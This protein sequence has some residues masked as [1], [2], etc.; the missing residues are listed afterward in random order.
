MPLPSSRRR[1]APGEFSFF[2]RTLAL[3][4][5]ATLLPGPLPVALAV[6]ILRHGV[7]GAA[8]TAQSQMGSGVGAGSGADNT[9][10]ARQNATDALARTTAA[11]D[12]VQQM[13]AAAHAL[14][15]TAPTTNLGPNP[16]AAG[17][18]PNVQDGLAPGGL[19]I[20][21]TPTG[22][23]APAQT[24][25]TNGATTVN[26]VQNQ[27]QAFINW[28]SF[29]IGKNTTLNFDQSAGGAS[30]GQWIAF[31]NVTD[32]TGNPAQILGSIHAQ[33]QV[34][35]MDQNGIIFGGSSQVNVNTLVAS[36]LPIN[37]NLVNN[38]LLNQVDVQYLFSALPQA[39]GANGTPAV[40][41]DAPLTPS[42]NN[43]DVT[44]QA[45]AQLVS[46]SV[47]G[48]GGRIA[49]IGP[50]VTNNGSISTP[51]GQTIIAGGLQVGFAAHNSSD[52]S[53]RGLD[54]YVGSVGSYGGSTTNTG[55]IDAPRGNVTMT[56][57]EVNQD[58]VITST[59]SVALNGRIDLNASYN[60][61]SNVGYNTTLYP[62]SPPYLYTSS[63]TVNVGAGAVTQILPEWA[64]T[65][66][67]VGTQLALVSQ[68][69]VT[70]QAIY[71][72]V[73]STMLAPN[74]QVTISAGIWDYV[75]T[76]MPPVS[77][78]IQTG[79]QIY[80]DSGAM[81]NVAGSTDV[82]ASVNEY[83]LTVQLRSN[84]L[85]DSP[86]QRTGVLDNQTVTVDLR[87]TGT[88]NGRVW[89]GT[90]LADLAGY[91]GVIQRTVGELTT[92]GGTISLKAGDSVVLQP[93]ANLNVSG[94]WIN[95]QGAQV[96]TTQLI[97][98][99]QIINIATATPNLVYSGIYTGQ[100]TTTQAA[101]GATSTTTSLFGQ[102][103]FLS[104]SYT[105][106]GN[107]GDLN[108]AAPAMALDGSMYGL[109][110]M[111]IE[112]R[113]TL[114]SI[115]TLSLSF[116]AQADNSSL[117]YPLT[118]PTQPT[119]YL[120]SG[121][122]QSVVAPFAVSAADVPLTTLS[123]AR[124]LEV[125]LSPT[126]V[127]TNGF[128]QLSISNVN[129]SIIVPAATSLITAPLGAVNF[130]AAIVDI[131]GSILSRGGSISLTAYD[132][133]PDQVLNLRNNPTQGLPAADLTRG[134][135][136]IGANAVLAT[137]GL[138]VDE[139]NAAGLAE[140]LVTQGGSIAITGMTVNL[141]AGGMLDVSGGARVS[142]AAQIS[143]GNGGAITINSGQDAELKGV[144][145]G[146]LT[147]DSIMRGFS[148]ATGGALNLLAPV[149]QV[150]GTTTDS[151][152]LL[153]DP[154]FF[155]QGGFNSFTLTGLGETTATTDVFNPAVVIAAGTVL[156]PVAQS[157]V[158]QL[159]SQTVTL[160]PQIL[161]E[162][163]RQAVKLDFEAPG[164]TDELLGL[165]VVRGE[166]MM[167]A[168]S[169]IQTDPLG[170]VKFNGGAV[171]LFG[172][173]TAPGGTITVTGAD[174]YPQVNTAAASA[175]ITVDLAPG[176]SL[177]TAGKTLLVPD[178]YGL[179]KG[180]VLPG[181]T[182]TVSGNIVAEAGALLNASGASGVLDLTPAEAGQIVHNTL[183]GGTANGIISVATRID[184]NGG[185]ISFKGSNMLFLDAT[186]NAQSGGPTAAG[187]SL[188]ISSGRFYDIGVSAKPDDLNILVTQ[189]TPSI[190]VPI[191]SAGDNAL[192]KTVNTAGG[193]IIAQQGYFHADTFENGGF[194][195]LTLSGNL[196][197]SGAVTL[198]AASSLT[199]ATGGVLTA[200]AAVNLNAPYVDLGMPFRA[201]LQS[202]QSENQP[203]LNQGQPYYVPPTYGPGTLSVSAASIDIGHLSLQST[204]LASFTALN[205][206][207]RGDGIL[208]VAGNITMTAGQVYTPTATSFTIAA[209]DYN[210]GAGP[211]SG[212]VTLVSSGL[213][214][215]PLSAGGTINVYAST[216]NQ[217]GTLVAPAG[218]INLGW[219][220]TGTSPQD[221]LSGAGI[222]SLSIP[223]TSNLNILAGSRTSVSE[224]DPISGLGVS[225]P[226][227]F[228]P[229]GTTW[230]DPTGKDI[231]GGGLPT[232]TVNTS[233]LNINV[234][235]GALID[236]RGG[237]DL[238]AFQ[239]V[240]GTGGTVDILASQGSFAV[241]PGYSSNYAPYA[242]FNSTSD[243]VNLAASQSGYTNSTLSVGDRV[244]LAGG[245]GLAAGV[246][247]LLP[248]RY[249]LLSGAFLVTPESGEPQGSSLQPDGA[250]LVSGYR[251]NALNTA[252]QAP[253]LYS[254]FEVAPTSVVNARA[255]YV[256]FN[257]S[258]FLQARAVALNLT[259][260][261]LPQDGG[262]LLLESV[263]G[264]TFN[265][266]IEGGGA[267]GGRGAAIDISS[268]ADILLASSGA[269]AAPGVLVLDAAQLSA[270]GAESLLI[271][272]QRTTT[273]AGTQVNVRTSNITVG[274]SAANSLSMPELI[275]VA[276]NSITVNPGASIVQTGTMV[277]AAANLLFGSSANPGSGNGA[278]L[279]VSSDVSAEML[280]S[281]VTSA[282]GPSLT[283][284][285]GANITGNSITLDSSNVLSLNTTTV[286]TG[287]A[288]N[289]DSGKISL[290]LNNP[291]T[292]QASPGLVIAG[293]VLQSIQQTHSLSLLSYSSI[294]IYGTGQVGSAQTTSL[295]LHAGEI[296]GFN[297][298]NPGSSTVTLTAQN[299]L[300]DNSAS[301]TVPGIVNSATGSLFLNAL[302]TLSIGANALNVDQFLG[303]NASAANGILLQGAGSLAV[304]GTF[305]AIAPV[306]TGA[307]FA[308][309]SIT[310]TGAM[311]LSASA[312]SG[313]LVVGGL[314]ASLSLTG[315]SLAT[316]T[317]I[318]LPSGQLSLNATSGD[319]TVTGTLNVGGT[320]Q[321]FFDQVKYT[322]AGSITLSSATGNVNLLAGSLV[323]IA[324]NAL[325]GNAGTL[326]VTTTAGTLNL[327]GTLSGA[328]PS[329][330]SGSFV[331]TAGTLPTLSALNSTLNNA[332]LDF[333]RSIRVLNGDVTVDGNTTSHIFNLSADQ[334]SITVTG[335][336]DASGAT[337][338]TIQLSAYG[339]IVLS[340]GLAKT[341]SLATANNLIS[342]SDTTGVAIGQAVSG[343]NIPAATYV[344]A[345][346]GTQITL[347]QAVTSTV[348]ASTSLNFGARLT[349]AAAN[350]DSA[351]KGGNISLMAGSERN[352][353][354]NTAAKLDLQTG[355]QIDL[356]VASNVASSTLN[357]LSNVAANVPTNVGG[358]D[359][360]TATQAGI[361]TLT[362]GDTLALAA[363]TPTSVVGAQ[364][365]TLSSNGTA[366]FA[367]STAWGDFTGTLQLRA[368]QNT[369]ATDLQMNP[370]NATITGASVITA[371]GY[372]IFTPTGGVLNAAYF[373]SNIKTNAT[374]FTSHTSAITSRLLANNGN[375]NSIFYLLPGAEI[376]NQ[377]GDLTLGTTSSKASVGDFDLSSA[378]YGP[379]LVP[380]VLTMRAEGNLVFY[381]SI[382]D[383]FTSSLYTAP[384]QA[385]NTNLPANLQSWSY[386]LAA[387]SDFTAVDFHQV[388][389]TTSPTLATGKGSLLL[390]RNDSAAISNNPGANA[391]TSATIGLPTSTSYK[392]QTIRTGTGSIDI[393]TARDVQFL[394]QFATIYTAGSQVADS[395][396]GGTFDVPQPSMQGTI[397]G[398]LGVNQENP[399]PAQYTMAGG[400]VNINA[401][402]NIIQLAQNSN[403]TISV[404]DSKRSMPTNWLYRRGAVDPLTGLFAPS[405]YSGGGTSDVA[406]TSW[407][408]DFNN[409]FEN[410][411]ALGG[412]NITLVAGHNVSNINADI[413]TNARMVGKDSLGNPIA[414]NGASL[415]ELGGGSLII[416]SGHNIDGGVYYVERGTG[417]LSAQ[418]AIVTN[419]TRSPS[420]GIITSLTT[421][422]VLDSSTWLPTTLF[423]GDSS[424]TVKAVGDIL[425][426]PVAN[427]FLM[428]QGYNNSY[429]YKTYFSTYNA[430]SAVNVSSLAGNVTLRQSITFA[431]SGSVNSQVPILQAWYQTQ[432]LLGSTQGGG[433]GQ[434]SSNYQPWL[435]LAEDSLQP[436]ATASTLMPGTLRVTAFTGSFDIVGNVNLSPS[437]TGTLEL[438]AAGAI[439]G[440]NTNGVTTFN[441]VS[442]N[443]WN[444]GTINL[445]DV[446]P[447]SLP[448]VT[449]PFAYQSILPSATSPLAQFTGQ[450]LLFT[451]LDTYFNETGS[452]TGS[453]AVLQ[454]KQALH[455]AG[456]LHAND[457]SPALIYA[458]TGSINGFTLFSA[459]ATQLISGLD[460]ADVSLY[461]QN[462][463]ASDLSIVASGRDIIP[464]DASTPLRILAQSNGNVLGQSQVPQAGDIQINGP[465]TLEVLS[466]RNIDLGVG[467]NNADGTG[468]GI[469]SIGNGRNPYLPFAGADII[470]AAGL[471]NAAVGISNSN[472]NFTSLISNFGTSS[473]GARYLGELEDALGIP[474]INLSDPSLSADQRDR[475]ALALFYLVLRDAGRDYNNPASPNYRSY[476]A[477]FQA[478]ADLF[479][480]AS[481]TGSI[482]TESRDIRTKSG[483]NISL[484]APG[485]GLTLSPTA[486]GTQ[487]APPGIITEAGGGINIFTNTSVSIGISRIFT[488]KGGDI[489]IWSSTGNI[490][491]GSSAKTV[492]SA[493]PTR[494]IIDP[495]S[496]SV[497]TD[498]AGLATGGGIGA[499]ATLSTI[500]NV[501]S[502]PSNIDLI[503]PVGAVDAGDAGIRATGNLNIAATIVLNSSNIQ[504]AGTTSGAPSAP[505]VAS[506]NIGGLSAANT[507]TAATNT[508]AM[509]QQ[510]QQQQQQTPVQDQ[511]SNFTVEVLGYGGGS[512]DTRQRNQ[513]GE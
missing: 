191:Y 460:I 24:V 371:E 468:A 418:G 101:F 240:S 368:P 150:G 465:G 243:S 214:N 348:P 308:S 347:S 498:L 162:G 332:G 211:Q 429:W 320:G 329:G 175:F 475:Y 154:A 294:D 17:T 356:S 282:S 65:A 140:P 341:T 250:S 257:A 18:L 37:D 323:N 497:N 260:P 73:G 23:T 247:T 377:T 480:N 389:A 218:V 376:I 467:S 146:G 263:V 405:Q 32:P 54:V 5:A 333:S 225:I 36:S 343:Q 169:L 496:G 388:L 75:D 83:I 199:L 434:T 213:R 203:L 88:Y 14:A 92:A 488:L 300:I 237:G 116:Q 324:A 232:K 35:V 417:A 256:G 378:R 61:I 132:I 390:G 448:S 133:A 147:L 317:D 312:A 435:K 423:V 221:P 117:S 292:L 80:V 302:N 40:T 49:L 216:I 241:L 102:G 222:T 369:A 436:F 145:G 422:T 327:G 394:N 82:S 179:R 245:S 424:F 462:N 277:S 482:N 48:S 511:E 58:G 122:V 301:G 67:V 53:L 228:S 319:T 68:I 254:S 28:S 127:N 342:L 138:I 77:T 398:N 285:A 357:L 209:Y 472:L 279:R 174:K 504:V 427:P 50:N 262:N 502:K 248:A 95:Y 176:S 383:G 276:N 100:T 409:F 339:S 318:E 382:S 110:V 195:S 74:A 473:T 107:G 128:G 173:V 108:I 273:T 202:Q 104:P 44:V 303:L 457:L 189:S 346:N 239:W 51:D 155:S 410:V 192:G 172:S 415:V 361:I 120:R 124:S 464:Y 359:T 170:S 400:N 200:N 287:Q 393:A 167:N 139:R 2:H 98:N 380:G 131:E 259:V 385:V 84:E 316:G 331:L 217:G 64:S 274:N 244:Y 43:G 297:N 513:P 426:G 151:R 63:G 185:T 193:S 402:G 509:G 86:L 334:G 305:S 125:D 443:V 362:N 30:V 466:G 201:P 103:S 321:T 76:S 363:N 224:I 456:L 184:S 425:L 3:V 454:T 503:A 93:T 354:I 188:S 474:S 280:R 499:L 431:N 165:L 70:G 322:D 130:S 469:T 401:Q 56:G 208:D 374:T 478:I 442:T 25:G 16:N 118:Y 296:R 27:Q 59:T 439:N 234:Q 492:Q 135:V 148:G 246:Y 477:G 286:L 289:I 284:G 158:A 157:W 106:G 298:S 29:N 275:L 364:S 163:V 489:V 182:I 330:Q 119:V 204:G 507:S 494:V 115:S 314:G 7:G 387:G 11:I 408:V 495:Q 196:Q 178:A 328:A 81:I 281:G 207:I 136:T 168:G 69:N 395:T 266:E 41:P 220:G 481:S 4:A 295:A 306:I 381:D 459:K 463:R 79:G 411:G 373:N 384:L 325:G 258:T 419:S 52:P 299:L 85:A 358:Y 121:V 87:Q 19:Q 180:S 137:N 46:P 396:L 171:A 304:Q 144:L 484:F 508:A 399:I 91:V 353:V 288:L 491:A 365:I 392:F 177:S 20:I 501:I 99:G 315:S 143:Y 57:K 335:A 89:Y 264:M 198:T 412:G 293:T 212:S 97:Y 512:D 205:G 226:Y 326:T 39:A 471:G 271:G 149:I 31:N 62:D 470:A 42:G 94:G 345:I 351:G 194:D 404:S 60:A 231:T 310:S 105:Q 340:S 269:S 66:T 96:Q 38:G 432:L 238:F 449:T 21:G 450:S 112:Q 309:Q 164:V 251:F 291:G 113:S 370:I 142:S 349:A 187:G 375:L 183:T 453:A 290:Q 190:P 438:L 47:G 123:A 352:G 34:Y 355:S 445:S 366:S 153:L 416:Q 71:F 9:A 26:I 215:L 152:A 500:S 111:G 506:P 156:Q 493:P 433:G 159:D 372:K 441:G 249:A 336:I 476:S 428:P 307:A 272:G 78:F 210:N 311:T 430:N 447:A 235:S 252:V 505:S 486:I 160:N 219:D 413:P 242:P 391:T 458:K 487:L 8:G 109:T 129:G 344:V 490:A 13:Q 261:L 510:Q 386:R 236:L 126:L 134:L 233:A 407:W 379:N 451:K 283:I 414:P 267:T 6:D 446:N 55:S 337:G 440:L 278:L 223:V 10:A 406:S 90:P 230:I 33:G 367:G 22:A 1:R 45:G 479:P 397:V 403:G 161:A 461:L 186:L 141:A 253:Q 255:Q 114:P 268:P 350:F 483:G 181:G 227:G 452:T 72:G 313:T 12:A 437:P 197:F 270:F 338:G 265:G 455:A 421:P 420:L 444:A 485:G 15:L 206:D 360:I 166:I 229:D